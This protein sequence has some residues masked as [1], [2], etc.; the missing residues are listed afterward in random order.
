MFGTVQYAALRYTTATNGGLIGAVSPLLIAAAGAIIFRD[1][2][3][4]RVLFGL[5]MSIGGVLVVAFQGRAGSFLKL[6]ANLGDALIL[7]NLAVWGVYTACL[8]LKAPV[9]W[10]SFTIAIAAVSVLGN[11]PVALVE[12]ALGETLQATP[13]TFVA[14]LYTSIATSVVAYAAWNQG[15]AI[16]GSQR[17]GQFLNLTPLFSVT[18][19]WAILGERLESYHAVA[20]VLIVAGI[21][22]ASRR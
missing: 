4:W 3:S 5:L 12:A 8:R 2:I 22:V 6:E 14:I 16:I 9:H 21:W 11:I 20:A 13:K 17:A 1:R 18:A 19:A 10:L 15:V 7:F